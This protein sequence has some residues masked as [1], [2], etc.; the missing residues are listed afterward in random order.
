MIACVVVANSRPAYLALVLAA[1]GE[2]HPELE[3]VVVNDDNREGMAANVQR[4]WDAF[5]ATDADYL[6]HM[7]DDMQIVAP[8]PLSD[9]VWELEADESLA[10]MCFRREPWWGAPIEMERGDQLAAICTQAH[11]VWRTPT[12]T[13]HD[14][15]FSLNPCLIPR[16]VVELGWPSGPLGVG[17]ESGMTTMLLN[18]GYR[19]GSWGHPGDG[20]VWARHIGVTR[21]DGWKL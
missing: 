4:A 13:I 6:L 11:D 15:L 3:P 19:F 8:M 2:H 10:Q 20:Q 9:A 17:N 12:H 7:E 21:G 18:L 1:L 5:L 16:R 14:W